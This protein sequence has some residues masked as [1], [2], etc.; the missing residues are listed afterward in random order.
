MPRKMCPTKP[1]LTPPKLQ[2]NLSTDL[3]RRAGAFAEYSSSRIIPLS[4]LRIKEKPSIT[5]RSLHPM[6]RPPRPRAP[7]RFTFPWPSALSLNRQKEAELNSVLTL[8]LT[9][10]GLKPPTSGGSCCSGASGGSR[11]GS[12]ASPGASSPPTGHAP[13]SVASCFPRRTPSR[14]RRSCCGLVSA[15]RL[16]SSLHRVQRHPWLGSGGGPPIPSVSPAVL[17]ACSRLLKYL[18]TAKEKPIHHSHTS[19]PT[20]RHSTHQRPRQP[21]LR[22]A[23]P[24]ASV[25]HCFTG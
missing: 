23:A 12:E 16:G 4:S 17:P 15:A 9:P 21:R 24:T 5:E 7:L 22:P 25:H 6:P 18:P 2:L 3:L 19:A 1:L 10:A 20:K 11:T 14:C 13:A 8:R